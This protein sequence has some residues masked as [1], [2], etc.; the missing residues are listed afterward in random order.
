MLSPEDFIDG[1]LM[2]ADPP[3]YDPVKAHQY[4]LRTR[5][6]KGRQPGK[7][8]PPTVGRPPKA[9]AKSIVHPAAK[10]I[11]PPPKPVVKKP[12]APKKQS[13]ADQVAALQTRLT[14]LRKVLADLVQQA[15]ARS[16]VAS[17]STSPAKKETA[18]QKKAAS[19][20]AKKFYD[21]H[22]NNKTQTPSQQLKDLQSKVKVI[23]DKIKQMRAEIAADSKKEPAKKAPAKKAPAKKVAVKAPTKKAPP[24]KVVPKVVPKKTTSNPQKSVGRSPTV[25]FL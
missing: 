13:T 2:H 10:V 23:Q 20:A 5:E 21:K 16:G 25:R 19:V 7:A 12:A 6:L 17:K 18:A 14:T 4:Y 1:L 24:K 8:I 15:K 3:P 11:K 9:I 22:K